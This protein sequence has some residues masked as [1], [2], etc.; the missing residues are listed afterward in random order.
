MEVAMQ[1][2]KVGEFVMCGMSGSCEVQE[3]GPLSFGGPD[4]IYYSLKPVYDSRDTIYVSVDRES[5]IA[6]KV[7][8]KKE[9]EEMIKVVISSKRK[10][11]V[12]EKEACDAILRSADNIKISNMIRQLR[13]LRAE[14]RKNH[15]GLN[16]AEEKILKCAERI[17][18]SEIATAL[19][20][21]MED[22][23]DRIS[24]ELD[25]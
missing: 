4:K 1:K 22:A 17:F 10:G 11:T 14:N 19:N 2:Y 6:R 8:S 9:A 3:I 5:D 25:P 7:V 18:F 20:I 21:S 13:H 16:I 12:P 24:A 15:K 23:I